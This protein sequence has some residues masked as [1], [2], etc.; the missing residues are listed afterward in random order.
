MHTTG[1][2][3]SL[4]WLVPRHRG[5]AVIAPFSSVTDPLRPAVTP[6]TMLIRQSHHWV[7]WLTIPLWSHAS[8]QSI[9]RVQS[10]NNLIRKQLT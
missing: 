10:S 8:L 7:T 3:A 2:N 6:P 5:N 4:L 1:W 9:S